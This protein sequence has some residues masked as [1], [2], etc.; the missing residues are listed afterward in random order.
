MCLI[1][2]ITV[3]YNAEDYLEK[4]ILS[5]LKAKAE[6]EN[7]DYIII[8]GF[9]SDRT[10]NIIKEY[11]NHLY[12]WSSEPDKGIYDAMNK[13]WE[14]SRDSLYFIFGCRR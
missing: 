1:T 12:Y 6:Y 5:V 3:T 4:T 14:K 10:L 7:I 2:V 9:S 11:E 13:G 8:D